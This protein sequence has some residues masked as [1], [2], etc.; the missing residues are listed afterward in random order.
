MM[1]R[2]GIVMGMLVVTPAVATGQLK[3]RQSFAAAAQENKPASFHWTSE[4]HPEDASYVTID[5]AARYEFDFG[6]LI[7]APTAEWHKLTRQGKEYD[8]YTLGAS[9]ELILPQITL[10]WAGSPYIAAAAGY[11]RERVTDKDGIAASVAATLFSRARWAPGSQNALWKN[12]MLRYYPHI[13]LQRYPAASD[14]LGAVTLRF[15]RV[16]AEFWPVI[17]RVQGLASYSRSA[18]IGDE[19]LTGDLDALSLSLNVY[20]DDAGRFAFGAD[21]IDGLQPKESFHDV[22][23]TVLG[24]KVKI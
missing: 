6:R 12:S 19:H 8:R 10:P 5:L 4:D 23:R 22:R 18:E 9:G 21:F 16:N 11:E 20:L 2:L 1:R 3:I 14:S 13:G 7:G 17:G 15:F 24:F